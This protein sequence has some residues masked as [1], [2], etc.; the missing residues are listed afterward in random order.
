MTVCHT[1]PVPHHAL[2]R[3]LLLPLVHDVLEPGES[4]AADEQYVG[5]V[6]LDELAPW[7]LPPALLRNVHHRPF[8]HLQKRLLHTLAGDVASDGQVLGLAR[9]LIDLVDVH[10]APVRVE[11]NT[12]RQ[13]LI[14]MITEII[15]LVKRDSPLRSR[16][17]VPRGLQ[18][19]MQ[20]ALHVLAHVPSLRQRRG[21]RDDDRDVNEL[22]QGFRE[23]RLARARRAA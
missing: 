12:R 3:I 7:V 16:Q 10:D 11:Q 22:R 8:H 14:A 13:D 15:V 19:L 9:Q 1:S 2:K 21:V 17:I 20:Q 23:Q 6:H 5:R 4:S 18:Q